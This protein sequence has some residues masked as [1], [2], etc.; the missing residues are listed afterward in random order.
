[1]NILIELLLTFYYSQKNDN[2]KTLILPKMNFEYFS[3]FYKDVEIC[4]IAFYSFN[5][6]QAF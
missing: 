2:H 1:M 6:L 4:F 5:L 3:A